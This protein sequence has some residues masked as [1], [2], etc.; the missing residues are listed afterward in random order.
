VELDRPTGRFLL[1]QGMLLA[2]RGVL[3]ALG[4]ITSRPGAYGYGAGGAV[5]GVRGPDRAGLDH[6][7]APGAAT[8]RLRT[9]LSDPFRRLAR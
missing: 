9:A 4:W 7:A 3:L 5:L 8:R 1:R 6:R 2:G